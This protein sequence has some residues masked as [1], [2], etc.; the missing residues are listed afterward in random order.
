MIVVLVTEDP[1]GYPFWVAKVLEVNKESK[2][3]ISF[4]IHWHAT[5]KHPFNGVYKPEMVSKKHTSRKRKEK[6]D[7]L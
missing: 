7:H 2:E 4:E 5:N 6:R 1:H 3:V